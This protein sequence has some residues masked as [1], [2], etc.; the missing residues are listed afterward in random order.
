MAFYV[1]RRRFLRP[2]DRTFIQGLF[3]AF[4]GTLLTTII[5]VAA[6]IATESSRFGAFVA[7]AENE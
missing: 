6:V 1:R 5:L 2:R 7:Q 4:I 3:G